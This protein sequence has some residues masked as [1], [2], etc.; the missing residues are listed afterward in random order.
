MSTQPFERLQE[1]REKAGFRSAADAAEKFEWAYSTYAAHENGSRKLTP[2]AARRYGRAFSVGAA[3]LLYG[4]EKDRD[5]VPEPVSVPVVGKVAAGVWLDADSYSYEDDTWVPAIRSP[6]FRTGRQVAYKVEGPSMNKVLPD[7]CYAIG[8]LF[9]S[10][11]DPQ[12]DDV[13]ILRRTRAGLV[14]TTVKRF[15]VKGSKVLLM[16][17]SDD[18]RYQEPIEIKTEEDGANVEI[19][20]L[21]VGSYRPL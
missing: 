14:E 2:D 5:A 19:H 15:V 7:G 17:E 18:P 1:A 20:A 13:V 9:D 6:G 8:V 11:R 3:W 10:A 16:P 4:A 21:V 12:N